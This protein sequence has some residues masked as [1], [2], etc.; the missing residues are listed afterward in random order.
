[1][2]KEE[3][4]HRPTPQQTGKAS[5]DR[6]AQRDAEQEWEREAGQGPN[7]E[8]TPDEPHDRVGQQV[9]G[10][11]GLAV[12]ATAAATA[13]RNATSSATAALQTRVHAGHMPANVVAH[14]RDLIAAHSGA[15]PTTAALHDG[16]A[17]HAVAQIQA[18]STDAGF[19]VGGIIALVA[20]VVALTTINVKRPAEARRNK[21]GASIGAP[22]EAIT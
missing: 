15:T 18:H 13:S 5:S 19:L 10:S 1:M 9:G 17:L 7:R 14:V 20:V 4:A 3:Q 11:I 21:I 22:S 6:P 12:L 2:V 8:R 16:T